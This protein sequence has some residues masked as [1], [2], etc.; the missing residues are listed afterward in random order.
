MA[1]FYLYENS[2]CLGLCAVDGFYN[3]TAG[4]GQRMCLGCWSASCV[5]C[6]G[7][8]S[9]DCTDCGMG[10]LVGGRCETSCDAA[11]S[12]VRNQTGECLSCSV[13]CNGCTGGLNSQCVLCRAGYFNVSGLC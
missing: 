1:G 12:W 13:A 7:G 6:V 4:N 3:I 2:T 8:G 10:F 11:T 9:A 5:R